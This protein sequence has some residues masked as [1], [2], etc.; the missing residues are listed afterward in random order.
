[1][2]PHFVDFLQRDDNLALQFEAAW[3]LMNIGSGTSEHTK[4]VVE[5]GVL[6]IFVRLLLSSNNDMR[7]QVVW[8]LG[9]IAGGSPPSRDLLL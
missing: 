9:N 5:V 3:A 7:E 6:P 1:M 8:A 2:V 4:V